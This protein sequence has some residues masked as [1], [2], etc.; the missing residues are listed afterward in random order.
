MARG[1]ASTLLSGK[2]SAVLLPAVV[3]M[4]SEPL[5]GAV[6]VAVQ[7]MSAPKASGLGTGLGTQLCVAPA[8]KPVKAQVGAAAPLGP[9][10]VHTPLTVT[11]WPAATAT[12][13]VV[14]ACMSACGT[15]VAGAWAW[16]FKGTKSTK[17]VPAVPVMVTLPLT[18]TV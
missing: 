5:T 16:L 15:T 1:L 10:L 11:L 6:K 2:G 9:A 4:F 14:T 18:G 13:T 12:G 17:L 8:G 7:V 3:V